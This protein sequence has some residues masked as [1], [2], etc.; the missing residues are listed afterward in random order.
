MSISII[1][2]TK[3]NKN[4]IEHFENFQVMQLQNSK[5]KIKRLLVSNPQDSEFLEETLKTFEFFLANISLVNTIQGRTM[6]ENLLMSSDNKENLNDNS[7]W[8]LLKKLISQIECRHHLAPNINP[9]ILIIDSY[10]SEGDSVKLSIISGRI[11]KHTEHTKS[12]E[13]GKEISKDEL[14]GYSGQLKNLEARV[15]NTITGKTSI[16]KTLTDD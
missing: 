5:A 7:T 10:K 3:K 8:V 2:L 15:L 13:N 11:S 16:Y 9:D 12:F 1:D 14:Q 4:S 6:V